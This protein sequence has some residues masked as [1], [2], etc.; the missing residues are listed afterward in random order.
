VVRIELTRP[1]ISLQG[2]YY[3]NA[4]GGHVRVLTPE[5]AYIDRGILVIEELGIWFPLSA[6][7]HGKRNA[8]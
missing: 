1:V 2:S 3:N 6:I 4:T 7:H 8:P 5:H